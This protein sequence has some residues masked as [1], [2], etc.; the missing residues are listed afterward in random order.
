M[1]QVEKPA[2]Y[3]AVIGPFQSIGGW[4]LA[5]SLWPGYDPITNTISDLAAKDSPVAWL[6][7]AFFLL[8]GT[9]TIV[10]GIYAK[11]FALPGRVVLVLA[12]LATYGLTYFQT[13]TQDSSSLEHRIFASIAF[14]LWSAWPLF[15]M[16]PGHNVAWPIRPIGAVAATEALAAVSIWFL[17]VWRDPN[18]EA[19]GIAERVM[20]TVQAIYLSAAVIIVRRYELTRKA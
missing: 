8:G 17:I 13:P 7:S 1:R 4:A 9:L 11:S 19:E 6:M 15:S 18:F 5:G 14:I 10:G 16:R 20:V 3:A 12:G 2:Y